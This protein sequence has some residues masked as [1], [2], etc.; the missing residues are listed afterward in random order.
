MTRCLVLSLKKKYFTCDYICLALKICNLKSIVFES[1]LKHF[2]FV[3]AEQTKRHF[4][5]ETFECTFTKEGVCLVAIK[6]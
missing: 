6:R 3:T 5:L 4:Q 2:S 1:I